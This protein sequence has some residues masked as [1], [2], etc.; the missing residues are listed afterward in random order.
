MDTA[1]Q[2]LTNVLTT[3]V[4]SAM[5]HPFQAAVIFAMIYGLVV[6]VLSYWLGNRY[7]RL[8]YSAVEQNK[9]KGFEPFP[10]MTA[11]TNGYKFG[12]A[13]LYE[14]CRYKVQRFLLST[15]QPLLVRQQF[16]FLQRLHDGSSW[17]SLAEL[18]DKKLTKLQ[19]IAVVDVM[20][21]VNAPDQQIEPGILAPATVASPVAV[22]ASA[23][24]IAVAP[25]TGVEGVAGS[26]SEPGIS[27]AGAAKDIKDNFLTTPQA[28]GPTS[29][30]PPATGPA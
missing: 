30:V 21:R 19:L 23:G 16:D 27:V 7:Y 3:I 10:L 1:G 29:S 15:E 24:P 18:I 13:R 20:M 6:F 28:E 8:Y 11:T 9:A 25:V 26:P 4:I 22:P 5:R 14:L 2:F 17:L 12:R